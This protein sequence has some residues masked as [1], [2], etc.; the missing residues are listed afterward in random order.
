MAQQKK[1]SLYQYQAL[2]FDKYEKTPTWY[3]LF[4]IIGILL[5][6]YAIFTRSPMM[7]VVFVLT[8]I[9]TLLI[10]SKDPKSITIEI[11]ETGINLDSKRTFQYQDIESFGIF[12]RKDIRFIS[13]HMATG[14]IT[15]ARIPL[16]KENP[17]DIADILEQFVP[18]EDG[19]ESFFD[20]LDHFLK[21]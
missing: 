16:G 18:R 13:L 14:V 12:I 15:N 10:S 17:D 3:V 2:E 1:S 21:I 8:F 19:K 11:T 5:L 9:V 7:F 4:G 20:T 6:V